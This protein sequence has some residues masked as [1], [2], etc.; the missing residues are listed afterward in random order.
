MLWQEQCR[1]PASVELVWCRWRRDTGWGTLCGSSTPHSY[2]KPPSACWLSQS[3]TTPG[4]QDLCAELQR[5]DAHPKRVFWE[6]DVARR[7]SCSV[8]SC[9]IPGMYL[10]YF[11]ALLPVTGEELSSCTGV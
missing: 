2:I 9:S 11:L 10:L 3:S 6:G 7:D 4:V 5:W 8:C 1:V